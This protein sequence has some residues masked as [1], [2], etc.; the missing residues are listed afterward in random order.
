MSTAPERRK[1]KYLR[2]GRKICFNKPYN[3]HCRP[4]C[5]CCGSFTERE[6]ENQTKKPHGNADGQSAEQREKE[7]THTSDFHNATSRG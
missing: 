2:L 1:A 5:Y 6:P 4:D 3:K 7:T